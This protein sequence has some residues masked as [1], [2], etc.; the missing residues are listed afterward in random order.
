MGSSRA[1]SLNTVQK[2]WPLDL[3]LEPNY[4]PTTCL[5]DILVTL[6]PIY[7]HFPSSKLVLVCSKKHK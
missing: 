7:H 5:P 6:A 3:G 2:Q 1:M 4:T